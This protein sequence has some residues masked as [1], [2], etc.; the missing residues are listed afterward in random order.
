MSGDKRRRRTRDQLAELD[1]AVYDA[2]ASEHPATLRSVYY[3]VV[4]AGAVEKTEKAY[5]AVQR[6][7]L[8]MRRDGRIPYP[9][10]VDGARTKHYGGGRS[11]AR[12]AVRSLAR[13]YTRSLWQDQP[14]RVLLV[15]EKDALTTVLGQ[16]VDRWQVDLY[17]VRG[18]CSESFAHDVAEDVADAAKLGQ[19]VDVLGVGDHD[20][21]GVD[22]WRDFEVKVRG[23]APDAVTTFTRVAVTPEQITRL[24]LLTRPTKKSDSRAAAF[25]GESVEVDAIAPTEL[26]RLVDVA[27]SER[28]DAGALAR[29][30]EIERA[31]QA[32][33]RQVADGASA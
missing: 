27:I 20:P 26:R 15:S 4:S 30:Y 23:F 14:R 28:V 29:H 3:R 22:A 13:Y 9:W 31:E 33:L 12:D 25:K 10:I 19:A 8:E 11:N 21:S 6:R 16:V 7:L 24:G 18:Y 1:Q 17:V 5:T 32:W 2:A